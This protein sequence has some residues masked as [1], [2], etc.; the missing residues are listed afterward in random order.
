M[1]RHHDGAGFHSTP[2]SSS[3]GES[4]C[5]SSYTE[6]HRHMLDARSARVPAAPL[7]GRL[8]KTLRIVAL[9][10]LAASL[11]YIM[12]GLIVCQSCPGGELAYQS[13]GAIE[14]PE[15]A[16]TWRACYG[17]ACETLA[18]HEAGTFEQAWDGW[19]YR[20][21]GPD[22]RSTF[23]FHSHIESPAGTWRIE[24]F[25]DGRVWLHLDK[26]YYYAAGLKA[27]EALATGGPS[28][29]TPT[30]TFLPRGQ[31][32]EVKMIGEL[33]VSVRRSARGTPYLVHLP[34]MAE[35]YTLYCYHKQW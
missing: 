5:M 18:I 19:L 6:Q 7:Q 2:T 4:L 26:A 14:L 35:A 29:V 31:R 11:L 32:S 21:S 8:E 9:V 10:A 17:G 34:P 27:A 22:G 15:L 23:V 33:I 25:D 30:D 24:R 12:I 16:G 1:T 28:P 3:P 20:K 13:P